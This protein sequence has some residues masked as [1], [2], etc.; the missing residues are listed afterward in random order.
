VHSCELVKPCQSGVFFKPS[1][2]TDDRGEA[3]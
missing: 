3:S 2:R 1:L